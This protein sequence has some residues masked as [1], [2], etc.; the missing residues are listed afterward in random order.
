MSLTKLVNGKRVRLSVIEEAAT[1]A[2]WLQAEI[3]AKKEFIISVRKERN[4]RLREAD[5]TQLPDVKLTSVEIN[6]WRTYRQALRELPTLRSFPNLN[7]GDW[8]TKP[9]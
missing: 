1:R 6:N 9:V 4:N 3:E 2:G 7:E 5:W 8:P